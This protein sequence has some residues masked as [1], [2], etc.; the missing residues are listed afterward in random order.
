MRRLVIAIVLAA[1]A[2]PAVAPPR[3]V[4]AQPAD[5]RAKKLLAAG[6]RFFAELEYKKAI[7]VLVEVTRDPAA[8][9][10]QRVRAWELIALSRFILGD[11]GGARTAFERVLEA[12]PGFQ[13]RDTSG[14]PRIREFFDEVRAEVLGDAGGDVDLEHAAPR[15]GTAG[16]RLELEL[17]ATRGADSVTEVVVLHRKVGELA[18]TTA[19]AR[20]IADGKWRT[21]IALA[22]ARRAYAIEYYAEARGAGGAVLARVAT[23]DAPLVLEIAPGGGDG[24]PWYGRWYVIAGA[25]VVAAGTT[26]AILLATDGP[27]D[28]SLPPGRVT[29]TP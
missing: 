10:A 5:A 21:R 19:P 26:G 16:T 12:D 24:R 11:T 13:L 7:K 20:P 14:S 28:G 27:S 22:S 4:S 3:A 9:R 18:Y 1:A 25:A 17:R 29:V 8:S 15:A 23:P 2:L 6:E